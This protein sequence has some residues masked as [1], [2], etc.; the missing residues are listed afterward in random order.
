MR[1]I[2]DSFLPRQIFSIILFP[3]KI[4]LTRTWFLKRTCM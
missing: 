2:V 3:I 4:L 1:L